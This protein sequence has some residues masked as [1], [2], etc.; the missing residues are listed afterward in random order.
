MLGRIRR[1]SA[2][3][4]PRRSC[5][6]ADDGR[7]LSFDEIAEF[8]TRSF[9]ASAVEPLPDGTWSQAVALTIES[10]Q[11]VLRVGGDSVDYELDRL[12]ATWSCDEVPIPEVI[13]ISE[14]LGDSYALSRRV[15]GTSLDTLDEAEWHAALP[16]LMSALVALQAIDADTGAAGPLVLSS[17]RA[18]PR[19]SWREWLIAVAVEPT[20]RRLGQWRNAMAAHDE[21]TQLYASTLAQLE[22]LVEHCP[23]LR[24]VVHTDLSGN[25]F[26][27]EGRVTG[28][29]DWANVV[30]GDPAYD[31]AHLTFWA[32]W[33]PG[34]PEADL[35]RAAAAVVGDDADERVRIYELHVA[36]E[37]LRFNSAMGRTDTLTAVLDRM[38]QLAG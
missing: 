5:R 24:H 8:S 34:C 15:R 4:D 29:F 25:T 21:V 17:G 3:R 33:H 19:I 30:I 16:S 11:L 26:V 31:V 22:L 14:V 36:L 23:E 7:V 10:E 18:E 6:V 9:G 20:D 38:D 28:I 32:P 1:K 27:D 37:A 12:A 2:R 35:R 13:D